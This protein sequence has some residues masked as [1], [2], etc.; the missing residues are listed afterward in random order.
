MKHKDELRK[1]CRE[2]GEKG[3]SWEKW[4]IPNFVGSQRRLPGLARFLL[5]RLL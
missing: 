3:K 5:V 4:E 1:N 2:V